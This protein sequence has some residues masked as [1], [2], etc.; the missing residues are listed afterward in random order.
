MGVIISKIEKEQIE[1]TGGTNTYTIDPD[2]E[3]LQVTGGVKLTNKGI[4][5]VV[6]K[7][8]EVDTII[9]SEEALTITTVEELYLGLK[10]L[11]FKGK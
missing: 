5:S 7:P 2:F 11:Y 1:V 10:K 8:E 3:L 6:Y 9:T 4:L